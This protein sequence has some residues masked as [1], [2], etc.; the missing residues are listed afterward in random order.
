MNNAIKSILSDAITE[1]KQD[2]EQTKLCLI[3]DVIKVK[4]LLF[5]LGEL[6]HSE[7][8][9]DAAAWQLFCDL[10]ELEIDQLEIINS[11]YEKQA[12]ELMKQ[13]VKQLK[14]EI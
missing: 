6:G 8:M 7:F 2:Y 10:Y 11:G 14:G 4:K 1:G 5:G 9:N 12:T 3:E 13:R